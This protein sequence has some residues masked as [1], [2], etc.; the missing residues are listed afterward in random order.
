MPR[1]S[2]CLLVLTPTLFLAWATTARA[3]DD[4]IED[5]TELVDA[6]RNLISVWHR[7]DPGSDPQLCEV[8]IPDDIKIIIRG[9]VRRDLTWKPDSAIVQWEYGEVGADLIEISEADA[10]RL[11]AMFRLA[12]DQ[13]G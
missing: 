11:V 10:D 3:T 6:D 9:Q 5:P 12:W 7:F 8:L 4:Y 13:P 2:R 1:L